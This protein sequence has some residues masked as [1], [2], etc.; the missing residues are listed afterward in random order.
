MD[1][2]AVT[3]WYDKHMTGSECRGIGNREGERFADICHDLSGSVAHGYLA[4]DAVRLWWHGSDHT[5]A[6]HWA[7]AERLNSHDLL[8]VLNLGAPSDEYDPE[9]EE[10]SRLIASRCMAL[11]GRS[12]RRRSGRV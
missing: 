11:R 2:K 5:R 6:L 7:V 3:P 4:K 8:S 12:P 10:F 9:A 1:S